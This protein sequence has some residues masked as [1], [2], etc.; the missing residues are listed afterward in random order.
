M[1]PGTWCQRSQVRFQQEV[2]TFP[3]INFSAYN[4]GAAVSTELLKINGDVKD[5]PR[6]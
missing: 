2:E 6:T 1:P 4:N 5:P 3:E